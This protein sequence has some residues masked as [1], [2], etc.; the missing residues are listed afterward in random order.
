M[1]KVAMTFCSNKEFLKEKIIRCLGGKFV[2][3]CS[4]ECRIV[5]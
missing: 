4:E 5:A 2:Q 1:E 3:Y